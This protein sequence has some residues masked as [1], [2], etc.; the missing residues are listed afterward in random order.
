MA[1]TIETKRDKLTLKLTP[2][3]VK[4]MALLSDGQ[5]HGVEEIKPLLYDELADKLVIQTHMSHLRAKLKPLGQGILTE[6]I[7]RKAHYRRVAFF[8]P[9]G[10]I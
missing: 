5:P 1:E 8:G 4:I 2:T 6:Y 3:E 10:M 7:N 9:G